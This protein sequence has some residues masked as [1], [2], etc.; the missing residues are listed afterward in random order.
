MKLYK[1]RGVNPVAGCL[2]ALVQLPILLALYGGILTLSSRGLLNEQ[3]LWFNL[4]REDST[5]QLIGEA[6]P[7]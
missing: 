5:I 1:E 4:A 6:A 2:P 7:T 3:F